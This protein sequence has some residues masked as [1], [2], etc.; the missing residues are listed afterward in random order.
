MK[1]L[2][3]NVAKITSL[4]EKD[5]PK[6]LLLDFDG[7]LTPIVKFPE[8]AKLSK[9]MRDLLQELSAKKGVY[10]AIISGR[11]LSDIKEKIRLPNII[12][13]GNHGLEGEVFGRKYSY[14]ITNKTSL[15]FKKIRG[16]LNKIADKFRGVLIEDKELVLSFHYR[17]ANKQQVLAI[18]SLFK[19]TLKP[20]LEDKLISVVLGKMVFDVRPRIN[21]NK[22]SFAKLLIRKIRAQTKKAPLVIFIGDDDTDEDVFQAL[23]KDITIKVGG[24]GQSNAKYSLRNTKEVPEFLKWM[25]EGL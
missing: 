2:W 7:T 4:L 17:L 5:Y 10:L 22:G 6:L 11:K 13:G 25:K 24:G 1:Y 18:K 12:Y 16:Q 19:K 14:S 23:E 15:T 3:Q 21:W 20:Y 9:E 8:K